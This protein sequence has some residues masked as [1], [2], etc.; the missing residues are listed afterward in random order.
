MQG[1]HQVAQ[2]LIIVTLA[3][4]KRLSLLTLLPSISFAVKERLGILP[5]G[6]V[7]TAKAPLVQDGRFSQHAS[8]PPSEAL[9]E[10]DAGVDGIDALD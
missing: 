2:R 7:P 8:L 9:A 5:Y 10:G 4:L 3:P 1:E 6:W